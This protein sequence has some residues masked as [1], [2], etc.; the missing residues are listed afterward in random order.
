MIAEI[1]LIQEG[2]DT[3]RTLQ[4]KILKLFSPII[5][6]L[7]LQI[8]ESLRKIT[9]SLQLKFKEITVLLQVIIVRPVMIIQSDSFMKREKI[10]VNP[11]L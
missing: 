9:V 1:Q 6:I 7:F 2:M 8:T 10:M 4:E 5:T 3:V 11:E